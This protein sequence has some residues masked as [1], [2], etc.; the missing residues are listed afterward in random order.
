MDKIYSQNEPVAPKGQLTSTHGNVMG[1]E[2]KLN[3]Q[4]AMKEQLNPRKRLGHDAQP[5]RTGRPEG[6][7]HF[8]PRQRLGYNTEAEHTS[9]PERAAKPKETPWT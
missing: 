1:K 4:V 6:A 3:M 2:Q 7:A 9:R 8:N 5:K